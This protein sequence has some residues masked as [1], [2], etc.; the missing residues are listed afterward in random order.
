MCSGKLQ[1]VDLSVCL[2][3]NPKAWR[4]RVGAWLLKKELAISLVIT[5]EL[6]HWPAISGA[7]YDRLGIY[8]YLGHRLKYDETVENALGSQLRTTFWVGYLLLVEV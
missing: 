2:S 1:L 4:A 3:R 6:L 8:Q 7:A 5:P